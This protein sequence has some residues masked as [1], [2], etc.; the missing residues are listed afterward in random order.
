METNEIINL[1]SDSFDKAKAG[2]AVEI[3]S[4]IVNNPHLQSIPPKSHYAFGWIIYYALHQSPANAIL[5]RKQMLARYLKLSVPKPHKLHSMILNEAFRLYKDVA[6]INSLA[7]LN[8]HSATSADSSQFSIV[9]FVDL[10]N[11]QNIRPT[12]WN[13]KELDG[14]TLPSTVEK[15]ITHYVNELKDTRTPAPEEFMSILNQA[16]VAYPPSANLLAQSAQVYILTGDKDKAIQ[17]L[18]EAILVSPSKS[19]LWNRLANLFTDNDHLRL[20]TSLLYKALQCPGQ[21]DFKGKIHLS[22]A[23]ALADGG[24]FPHALHEL[25]F[26]KKLYLSKGWNLPRL[27]KETEKKI[28]DGTLPADPAAIYRKIEHLADDFIYEALPEINV[29]KTF[30]KPAAETTDRFGNRRPGLIAWRLTDEGGN[31]YWFNPSR[32]GIPDNLP[33]DTLITIKTFAGQVVNARLIQ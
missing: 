29:R 1:I 27:Y 4:N 17:M 16:L 30:H 6:D 33:S 28:P 19:F 5:L 22:L 18:R 15:L 26:V 10:W 2:A 25:V 20:K 23:A 21:D 8:P 12:D 24:A 3:Y 32:F 11:L 31:N 13:R 9:K 14:K 7:R